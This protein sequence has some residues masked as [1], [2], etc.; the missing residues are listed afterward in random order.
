VLGFSCRDM[1]H[2]VGWWMLWGC[3]LYFWGGGW[4]PG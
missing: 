4:V 3:M 1:F 2:S